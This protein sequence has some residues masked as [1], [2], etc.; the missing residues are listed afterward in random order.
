MSIPYDAEHFFGLINVIQK[1]K[2]SASLI[3]YNYNSEQCGLRV[4][5]R[6]EVKKGSIREEVAK[7]TIGEIRN[8]EEHMMATK[9][10]G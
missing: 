6:Y 5:A 8:R 1:C 3:C 9:T 7:V 2:I 4:H 10:R